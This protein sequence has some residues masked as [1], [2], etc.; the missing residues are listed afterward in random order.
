MDLGIAGKV[1]LVTGGSQGIGLGCAHRFAGEGCK[2]VIAARTQS[3]IDAATAQIGHGAKGVSADCTTRAG[4][5]CAVKACRDAFGSAPDIAVFNVDSG[6]KGAFLEVDDETFAAANNNNVMAFRWLVQAVFPHMKDSG[7]GRILT[8]GTNSVK[9]PHRKLPRAAQNTYR[10]GAL[11]LSKTLS[12][13][14]GPFGIT[15]NTLGTG[16]IA[17]PQF[18]DVF[19]RIAE[20][21][22]QTYDEHV[23][24]RVAEWPV[25]RMGTPEDMASAAAFLCSDLAG[26]ITGQVLVIDGGNLETL[27]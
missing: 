10:V 9:Q 25:R 11:A 17:T 18:K 24:E 22:G 19:T 1:A 23:A 12:A 3:R 20:A 15:V 27:Q 13:E 14:L 6:P 7:W 4:I 21:N 8:I 5:A 16:A 2:V 26:Y